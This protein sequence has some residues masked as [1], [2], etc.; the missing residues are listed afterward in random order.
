MA[1]ALVCFVLVV[2]TSNP[3]FGQSTAKTLAFEIADIHPSPPGTSLLSLILRG[4]FI[5]GG[6][7]ELQNATLLDMIRIAYSPAKV[8]FD[9]M[10]RPINQLDA[11]KVVGGPSTLDLNRFDLIAKAPGPPSMQDMKLML[12]T[13]LATRFNLAV[14][15]GDSPLPAFA[16][17]VGKKPLLKEAAGSEESGCKPSPQAGPGLGTLVSYSCRNVTMAAFADALRNMSFENLNNN[18]VVDQT[19]L[20]GSWNFD[21]KYSVPTPL[22]GTPPSDIVTL[23]AAVQKQ[24]GLDLVLTRVPTPV[25]IVDR[26]SDEPTANPPGLAQALPPPPEEFEVADIKLTAPDF[27]LFPG[28]RIEVQPSG[29]VVIQHATLRFLIMRA[30]GLAAMGSE[31]LLY[32]PKFLDTVWFDIQAKA[33]VPGVPPDEPAIA[34]NN[35]AAVPSALRYTYTNADTINPML[36]NLLIQRFGLTFHYEER[37]LPAMTLTSA[38]PKLQKADPSRRT[39]CHLGPGPT[40]GPPPTSLFACDNINMAQFAANLPVYAA[41]RGVNNV[42]DAT[43]LEGAWNFTV[44]FAAAGSNRGNP[45]GGAAG[46]AEG[47]ENSDPSGLTFFE[48]MEK[49]LGL[50]LE[51]TKR[52]GKVMVIDHLEEKPKEP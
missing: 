20:K 41:G 13:L 26:A 10:G 23:T 42:V 6:R 21:L 39:G 46:A 52:P 18:R 19:G 36:R 44:T 1:R 14:H 2:I 32:G 38:K 15:N 24:L 28:S 31:P 50:K 37:P 8:S 49:Q 48:A 7:F 33:A 29:R 47:A 22:Y 3:M 51:T 4:P 9:A 5:A 16:L 35:P 34:P 45:F 17:M 30:W 25:L 12:Q 40:G 27:N 43:G 11:D